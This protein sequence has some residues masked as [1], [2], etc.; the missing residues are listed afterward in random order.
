MTDLPEFDALTLDVGGVFVVP[1]HERL[2]EALTAAGLAIDPEAFWDGHYRAMH[3][4]D[5]DQS[6]AETFEA[7][8][9]AFCHH[10]GYRGVELIRSAEVQGRADEEDAFVDVLQRRDGLSRRKP[11]A[12]GEKGGRRGDQFVKV[13]V[14]V[15]E[16]LDEEEEELLP[17]RPALPMN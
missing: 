2:H 3:A 14:R 1:H 6:P 15:P 17:S 5:A 9:P 8:V 4:V 12:T 11:G 10:L 13:D 16:K 7:Y